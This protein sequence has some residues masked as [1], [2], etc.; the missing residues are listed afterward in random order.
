[1]EELKFN[2][3][4]AQLMTL[5]NEIEDYGEISKEQYSVYLRLLSPFAP[6]LCEELWEKSGEKE[7]IALAP[8]PEYDE[9]KTVDSTVEIAVQVNGK[10][11]GTVCVAPDEEKDSVFK[12]VF[13]DE[14]LAGNFTG[15]T[16]VKEIYI[17]GKIVNIVVK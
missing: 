10:V 13:A 12:K 17:P 1:M 4:I 7:M 15:K 8:W 5:L 16:V 11:R 3:A 2:T 14:K 9:S 6:H